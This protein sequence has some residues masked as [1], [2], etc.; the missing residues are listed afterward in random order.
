M[1]DPVAERSRGIS[2]Q[3]PGALE[4]VP[5]LTGKDTISREM[6]RTC[7]EE[8]IHIIGTVQP[9]GFVLVVD[10]ATTQIVQVSSG[11][12]RHWPGLGHASRLLTA[13][14]ADWIDGLGASPQALLDTLPR[15]DPMA[16]NLQ[17]CI[18][19]PEGAARIQARRVATFEC[20]G[21]R[22]GNLAVLE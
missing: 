20:V 12:A 13:Q 17:P 6:E 21:H 19:V 2:E 9:H 8:P 3:L 10:I 14:L 5:E 7:G 18:A 16:L 11:A 22:V 15:T 4:Q 1:A